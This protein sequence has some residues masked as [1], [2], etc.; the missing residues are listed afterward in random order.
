MGQPL[1]DTPRDKLGARLHSAVFGALPSA[2]A[3]LL[4]DPDVAA[5]VRPLLARG[6]RPAQLAAR[7][8]ALP[9]AADPVVAV[10]GL[11]ERLAQRSCPQQ[12][13]D[14]E[15]ADREREARE[16]RQDGHVAA[17]D[18]A[19]AHGLAQARS[20]LGRP[21]HPQRQPPARPAAM[22][23]SCHGPGEFFVTRQVRLCASC[24]ELL[25]SGEVHLV[26]VAR[27]G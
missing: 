6:W 11:L 26:R 20:A 15:R 17:S 3:H 7:V 27:A 22:C 24:V 10:I 9:A 16:R 21:S 1:F 5:A 2:T 12:A 8:G 23:A 14:L 19:R 4:E 25:R 13:W 18:Q